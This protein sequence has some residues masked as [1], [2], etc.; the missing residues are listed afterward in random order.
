MLDVY[1]DYF[2]Q[3][4]FAGCGYLADPFGAVRALLFG[5]L[6]RLGHRLQLVRLA[7]ATRHV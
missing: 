5:S 3:L 6:A 1:L 7:G 2:S 4:L